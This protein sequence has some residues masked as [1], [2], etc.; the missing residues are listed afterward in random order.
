MKLLRRP[1]RWKLYGG[2]IQKFHECAVSADTVAEEALAH[3]LPTY[4]PTPSFVE[5]LEKVEQ[6][7]Q[8][9]V[10]ICSQI[11]VLSKKS[12]RIGEHIVESR[13]VI[14]YNFKK[15]SNHHLL[16]RVNRV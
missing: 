5:L 1:L 3:A 16:L 11:R 15:I 13:D 8:L 4:P 7:V 9:N 10:V 2:A 14:M 12:G 6:L